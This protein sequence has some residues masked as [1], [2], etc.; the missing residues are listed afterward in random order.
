MISR[1]VTRLISLMI[2]VAAALSLLFVSHVSVRAA[3][4]P[5][6]ASQTVQPADLLKELGDSK[7]TPTILFVGF[8]RLYNSATS[9]ARNTT[10]W[11]EMKWAFRS[12]RLGLRRYPAPRIW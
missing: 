2:L 7:S 5:W 6:S 11:R 3:S 10:A 1:T 12:S 9:R 8:N 4:D